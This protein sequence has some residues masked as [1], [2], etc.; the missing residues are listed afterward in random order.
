MNHTAIIPFDTLN[1][2]R[3]EKVARNRF[4]RTGSLYRDGN[5]WRLRWYEYDLQPDGTSKPRRCSEVM[6]RCVGDQA[7]GE[8]EAK[9]R[10]ADKLREVNRRAMRPTAAMALATFIDDRFVPEHVLHLKPGG[11]VHYTTN[12]KHVKRVLGH[13]PLRD[14]KLVHVQALCSGLLHS[15]YTVGKEDEKRGKKARQVGYSVQTVVH[16]KNVVSAIFHHAKANGLYAGENP[17]EYVKLPEMERKEKHALTADQVKALLA[18]LPPPAKEMAHLAV[19]TGMNIAEICGLQWQ[20]VN[21][22]NEWVIA[23]G[24]PIAPKTISVRR[25]WSQRKGPAA[26]HTLKARGRRR[27]IPMTSHIEKLLAK[28]K[29]KAAKA[30]GPV[31]A[32]STGKP[33]DAHNMF[34]RKLKPAAVLL[35]MPYVGWHTLRHTWA[36]QSR[37][38]AMNPADLTATIGHTDFRMTAH[39]GR[40]ALERRRVVMEQIG[41]AFEPSPKRKK[42][43]A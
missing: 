33:V 13:M 10:A 7:I 36:T 27:E 39:Y 20:D 15:T 28:Q 32:S 41:A 34:N 6:G 11:Q 3:E 26:Y 5:N 18:A 40:E 25:Q 24:E 9:A 19:L 29:P 2:P 22:A 12:L 16:V 14:V 43:V 38:A 31:F 23:G 42:A 1:L 30:D 8:K 4:Q 37:I 35:E 21:L 17:A